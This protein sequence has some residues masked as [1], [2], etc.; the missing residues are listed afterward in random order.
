MSNNR[1][2]TTLEELDGMRKTR[3][4]Y[5]GS[6]HLG[7]DGLAPPGLTQLAQEVISNS[8]DEYLTG[9]GDKITLEIFEDNSME[10][11]DYGRGIPKG[12]N[13]NDFEKVINALTKPH[14]SGK[15]GG[16]YKT[17]AAGMHG[18]GIKAVNATSE[19]TEVEAT[20]LNNDGSVS[21]FYIK[22]HM[23][24]VLEKKIIKH[25]NKSEVEERDNHIYDKKTGEQIV[26]GTR[27]KFKPD[28]GPVSE[29]DQQPVFES[30][31]W[32]LKSLKP[33]LE[34]S[35][36]LNAGLIIELIDNRE[37]VEQED[38]STEPLRFVWQ[39]ENGIEEYINKIT[40]SQEPL[41][42]IDDVIHIK[43][44]HNLGKLGDVKGDD[45][46]LEIN[47]VIKFTTDID[48]TI[49]SYANGVPTRLGGTHHDGFMNG[50]TRAISDYAEDNTLLKKSDGKITSKDVEEGL[51]AV[52]E[53]KIPNSITQFD[54]Q[55]KDR[56][57]TSHAR[58][59][60]QNIVQTVFTDWLYDHSKQAKIIV[61]AI[62]QS[63]KNREKAI[64]DRKASKKAEK[65]SKAGKLVLASKLKTASSKNPKEKEV[66]ITEG[67]SASNIKRDTR[68][69]AIFP[70]RG[71]IRNVY[72]LSLSKALENDEV[73]TITSI[74]GAGI[75]SSFELE[76]LQYDK[77][78]IAAD[79]DSDAD[80]IIL[81]L[82]AMFYKFFRP[83]VEAGKLYYVDPPLYKATK[84]INGE[85][86]ILMFYNDDELNA[87]RD[88]LKGYDIQRYKGLGEMDS[89]E[90]YDA[91]TNKETR[92]LV[93]MNIDDLVEVNELLRVLVGGNKTR[94]ER[95][96]W[97]V[98][99]VDFGKDVE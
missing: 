43:G 35:A 51:V 73:S 30:I 18:I 69:Q 48:A 1:D 88:E 13:K 92:R 52:F 41:E 72:D 79:A 76:D 94:A 40:S 78:I 89:D 36:L 3:G 25:W 22:F 24:E 39:Y 38:G 10:V 95:K 33:R 75:G 90:A 77:V 56:L 16:Q 50:L 97:I 17:G 12:K 44:E 98:D 80:H 20:G 21:H 60:V 62:I 74:L 15:W 46:F 91:I 67:D 61:E 32:T 59:G 14:T 57:S 68:T 11:I 29:N 54:G 70:I 9:F 99:N 53:A 27:I 45:N 84:Y 82:T 5:I 28:S 63:K 2:M 58:S 93:Q 86:H 87:K 23:T 6:T 85:P 47:G 65:T 8:I 83:L 26:R 4:M 19:Y 71:K 55:T 31:V 42:G 37:T 7:D 81:L 34:A 49:L 96:Q 66:F 64:K